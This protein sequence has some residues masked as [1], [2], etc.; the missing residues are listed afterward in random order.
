MILRIS[1]IMIGYIFGLF[2]TSYIY[3]KLHGIDIREHGSGNAGST[4]ML[5]TMGTK[6]GLISFFGD[7]LKTILAV[8]V[9][10]AIFYRPEVNPE[11][12]QLIKLYAAA[13]TILG[14]NFPFY[15]GF[16]GGKGIACTAGMIITLDPF[17]V[18]CGI[19]LFFSIF[20][21]THY[22]SLGS[23]CMYIAFFIGTV[24]MGAFN[25]G[26]FKSVTPEIAMECDIIVGLLTIMALFRHRNNIVRLINHT[27]K[28]V[29][30]KQKGELS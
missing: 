3:G 28:K 2:Q 18:I 30:L 24:I 27:E 15:L 5:R 22:V 10:L 23:I 20:F 26:C 1:C 12:L 7:V 11:M 25:L 4:N 8:L 13:G 19:I 6:A 16:K 29:Y 17:M 9:C 14:H 21:A